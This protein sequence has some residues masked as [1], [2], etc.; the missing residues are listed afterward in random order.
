MGASVVG[1]FFSSIKAALDLRSVL[2]TVRVLKGLR[3]AER[4]AVEA[5]ADPLVVEAVKYAIHQKYE[6]LVKRALGAT[7]ALATLGAGLAVL[8]ANPAGAALAAVILGGVGAGFFLYKLGRW[9]WKKWKTKTL[10]VKRKEMARALFNHLRLGDQLA[11]A[12]VRSL[13]LDPD[14]IALAPHGAALIER[15][16]KSA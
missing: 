8:I 10:G 9:A 15:K 4:A 11:V 16:L 1:I 3:D 14:A 12:A 5:G 13:H 2:S 6:K 7:V